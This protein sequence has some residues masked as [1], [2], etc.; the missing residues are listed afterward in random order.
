VWDEIDAT[1]VPAAGSSTRMM[2]VVQV[3]QIVPPGNSSDRARHHTYMAINPSDNSHA[4]A[5]RHGLHRTWHTLARWGQWHA[6]LHGAATTCLPREAATLHQGG[7]WRGWNASGFIVGAGWGWMGPYVVMLTVFGYLY[8][9]GMLAACW[10]SGIWDN[11][12]K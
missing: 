7:S 9:S 2:K 1:R 6:H 10:C 3:W 4:L 5:A 12:T 11:L 8:A